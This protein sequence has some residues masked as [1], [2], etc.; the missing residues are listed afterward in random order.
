VLSVPGGEADDRR[1]FGD[2]V[3]DGHHRGCIV[4]GRSSDR[5]GPLFSARR[6]LG[7]LMATEA[8]RTSMT[9]ALAVLNKQFLP[10]VQ[11]FKS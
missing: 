11:Y 7:A 4:T 2:P 6:G 9:L 8:G 10:K 1:P 5:H 3:R